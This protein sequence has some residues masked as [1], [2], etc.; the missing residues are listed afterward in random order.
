M[1]SKL[2]LF[3]P[4]LNNHKPSTRS[5]ENVSVSIQLKQFGLMAGRTFMNC[6]KCTD[7]IGLNMKDRT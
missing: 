1:I 5:M 7:C 3:Q 6:Y 4:A 2:T